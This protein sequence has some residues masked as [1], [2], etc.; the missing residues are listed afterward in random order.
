V[1]YIQEVAKTND[2]IL[3]KTKALIKSNSK[4]LTRENYTK[5]YE[6]FEKGF[7]FIRAENSFLC[8]NDTTG[9]LEKSHDITT[10]ESDL[11]DPNTFN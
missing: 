1:S 3:R 7:V 5:N 10:Q 9:Q 8:R 6:R 2:K 11:P 4:I